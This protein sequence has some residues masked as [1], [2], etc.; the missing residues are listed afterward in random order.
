MIS[1]NLIAFLLIQGPNP[2]RGRGLDGVGIWGLGM[3]WG[4]LDNVETMG[5]M[6]GHMGTTW[7]RRG[8]HV[9][10]TDHGDLLGAIG[11]T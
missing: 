11:T 8:Q 2:P 1:S 6:W 10:T 4:P 3:M 7:E 9:E 5:T